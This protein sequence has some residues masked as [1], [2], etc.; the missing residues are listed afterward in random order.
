M[1][2]IYIDNSFS[3]ENFKRSEFNR[4]KQ[5]IEDVKIDVILV[6]NHSFLGQKHLQAGYY[7]EIFFSNHDVR[8][9]A[10]NNFYEV[11]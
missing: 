2:D 11:P 10:A 8:F 4:I 1:V 9:I 7:M 5:D 6:K 3:D